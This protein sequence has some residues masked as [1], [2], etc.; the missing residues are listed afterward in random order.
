M[1]KINIILTGAGG[2]GG[3]GII[4][5]LKMASP[6]FFIIGLD[7]NLNSIAPAIA[8]KFYQVPLG[9]DKRYV[10]KLLGIAK[11]EKVKVI[12]PFNTRELLNLASHIDELEKIGVKV[13]L[14]S[15]ESLKI[16]NNKFLLNEIC[17]KIG[18]PYPETILVKSFSEFKKAVFKLG[19]PKKPVCV[20]PPVSNG[21]RGFRIIDDSQNQLSLFLNQKPTQVVVSFKQIKEI[22]NKAKTF[23]ELMVMEY[24][25]GE[26]YTV[27]ILA[28][29][30]KALV[31]IPRL[32]EEIKMGVSFRAKTVKEARIIQYSALIVKSLKLHGIVGLQFKKD[33]KG[34]P[35]I[36][37]AN[38]RIQ[39]T[40]IISVASGVNLPYLAVKMLQ[41]EKFKIPKIKWGTKMI[42]YWN[43]IFYDRFG[44]PFEI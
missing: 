10:P 37:E 40:N 38:P 18:V 44:K 27:D 22:F 31:I 28:G 19:Y 23:P 41:G 25:P 6:D 7:N 4:K 29:E 42:R 32:R 33:E 36:L 13:N 43:E 24:L 39:G 14:S 21:Q 15:L 30:G 2:P 8:D 17:K 5:S 34:I 9:N 11:K 26:E 20:K 3:P 12:F 35:K 16:A 1:K